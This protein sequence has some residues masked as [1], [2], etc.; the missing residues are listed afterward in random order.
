MQKLILII[1]IFLFIG[2]NEEKISFINIENNINNI[3]ALNVKEKEIA[4]SYI[5]NAKNNNYKLI[6][7]IEL[8][9]KIDNNENIQIIAVVPRGNYILGFIKGAKNFE[10]NNV[11]SGIWND[12]TKNQKEKF[13]EFLGDKE[14]EIIF[15]DNNDDRANTAA[16]WAKKL[17]YKNVSILIG[18]FTNWRERNFEVSFD[19]PECCKM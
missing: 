4:Q 16:I 14:K 8:K 2:C 1:A 15:Y 11:F 18:G 6:T 9:S 7:S 13:I 3:Q 5:E 10:F 19:M 17:G 12:D